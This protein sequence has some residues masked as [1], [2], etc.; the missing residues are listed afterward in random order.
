MGVFD[1]YT[2][3]SITSGPTGAP[4]IDFNCVGKSTWNTVA[5][6]QCYIKELEEPKN[7]IVFELS[8]RY[9]EAYKTYTCLPRKTQ[10]GS[11]V[12]NKTAM[13]D[14]TGTCN[15]TGNTTIGGT[16]TVNTIN[17]LE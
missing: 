17:I 8:G 15:I 4:F 9:L 5:C 3:L 7:C 16:L 14:V 6:I 2:A 13:L 1:A 11:S 10:I 12:D